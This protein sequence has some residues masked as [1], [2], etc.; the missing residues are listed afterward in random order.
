MK[1]NMDLQ[2]KIQ[3]E[4]KTREK[5]INEDL[6]KINNGWSLKYVKAQTPEICMAA[7]TQDGRD[8]EYV[9]EQTPEICMTAVK[10]N[11]YALRYVKEQTT[12]ICLAAAM[13]HIGALVHVKDFHML[14]HMQNVI[15]SSPENYEILMICEGYLAGCTAYDSCKASKP[16]KH[17]SWCKLG[18]RSRTL[19]P[20]SSSCYCVQYS[21]EEI[22]SRSRR[23]RKEKNIVKVKC[24]AT[25]CSHYDTESYCNCTN[26]HNDLMPAR[27]LSC[28]DYSSLG[29]KRLEF[30]DPDEEKMYYGNTRKS[31]SNDFGDI[32]PYGSDRRMSDSVIREYNFPNNSHYAD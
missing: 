25:G 12:E 16:H 8:L 4:I 20:H 7:V 6:E 13:K 19:P 1:S 22:K 15:I 23:K 26:W 29:K 9:K 18:C 27:V 10:Q 17:N 5:I 21:G 32:S 24:T 2:K 28:S 30:E 3:E 14:K 31:A 11:G